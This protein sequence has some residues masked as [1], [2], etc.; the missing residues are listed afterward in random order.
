MREKCYQCMRPKT[1]CMCP[2]TNP[3]VT[4]TKF[5]ILMH[6]HEFRKIKNG[7]GRL[8]HL[9]LTNSEIIIDIDFT[10]NKRLNQILNDPDYISYLLYPGK[11]AINLSSK[12]P[13]EI[14]KKNFAIIILDATWLCAKK[15]MKL[16]KNL[17]D[18]PRFSFDN[19]QKSEFVLKQQPNELCLS[20]IE[21]TKIVLDQLVSYG[22]ES[23]DTTEFLLPFQKMIE[24]QIECI[25]NPD[26]K[27][28]RGKASRSLR[29]KTN[30][31]KEKN[32]FKILF[33][34]DNYFNGL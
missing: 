34:K 5:V 24:Y 26:N 11:E 18:L 15:M 6:P 23:I 20:T 7:T 28:Y 22:V 30:Y 12:A 19:T 2:H 8:T 32:G 10:H 14:G 4:N 25:K 29:E 3:K 1:S 9:Q 33:E 21:S 13:P 17:H 27:L 31:R 16:S